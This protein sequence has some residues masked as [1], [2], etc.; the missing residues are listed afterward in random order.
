MNTCAARVTVLL[1]SILLSACGGS[2]GGTPTTGNAQQ[3]TPPT[4]TIS[5][6]VAIA[7][8]R[9]LAGVTV[10]AYRTN[11]HVLTSTVT[12]ANGRYTFA[13][14]QATGT[15]TYEI[16]AADPQH[17][18]RPRAGANA[19]VARVDHNAL[20]R[21]VIQTTPASGATIVGAD[22]DAIDPTVTSLALART[23]QRTSF[24]SGDD[25][26]LARGTA[27]PTARFVDNADGT[28]GDRLTGLV[29]LKDSGCLG[30]ADWN[31]ALAAAAQLA[32]GR[33]GL[34]DGSRAGDWRVPNVNELESLVDSSQAAPALPAG[35]PFTALTDS[36]WTSTTYRGGTFEAWV[37]RLTDGRWIND[38]V[39]NVKATSQ[40]GV[41]AVRDGGNGAVTLAATGQFI[42]Y[43]T[44]DD[45]T[46][47]RGA[48]LPDLRF[49]DNGNGTVTDTM[50][51]L[52]WLK[53]GDCL[54][55][56]WIGV[57]ATVG[58]LAS[59]QCGLS[60][61]S[62]AGSWRVP[63]RAEML[64]LGDRAVDNIAAD[65]ARTYRDEAGAIERLPTFANFVSSE[66][67]WTSTTDASATDSAWSIYSCDFGVYDVAKSAVGYAMAVR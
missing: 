7:G 23:G 32:A 33:C 31:A 29:W 44:G 14:L 63:N 65:W 16:Y 18:Y 35:H 27:W 13:G 25:G 46:A 61:G 19:V 22:F 6:T 56:T 55:D 1:F 45:G 10:T 67:Y 34:A 66:Y 12:D 26:A 37:I 47:R 59:G 49:V 53:R 9:A 40:R 60:D 38:A 15:V 54:H 21:V 58:A 62:T 39:S 11:D 24:A 42:R 50:T 8:G 52:T 3:S 2:G 30:S 48:A 5:G 36:Y 20:Y 64:S 4:A 51:G 28:V 43:G 41:W 17:A 57:L